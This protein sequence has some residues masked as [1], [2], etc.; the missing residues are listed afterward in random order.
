MSAPSEKTLAALTKA[1]SPSADAPAPRML[2]LELVAVWLRHMPINSTP[3]TAGTSHEGPIVSRAGSSSCRPIAVSTVS[4][5]RPERLRRPG[6]GI[7]T[8]GLD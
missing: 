1:V 2:V 8:G 3:S 5:R 7:G 6:R 4:L